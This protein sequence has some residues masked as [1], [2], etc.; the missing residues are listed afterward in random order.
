MNELILTK[1]GD[2]FISTLGFGIR[3]HRLCG[4]DEPVYWFDVGNSSGYMELTEKEFKKFLKINKIKVRE[5][6]I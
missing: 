1:I 3:E 6:K 2:K 4:D 5:L